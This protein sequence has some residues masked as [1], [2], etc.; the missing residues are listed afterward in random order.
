MPEARAKRR[1]Y[2]RRNRERILEAQKA[3]R[4]R[5]ELGE[6]KARKEMGE[7]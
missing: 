2:Y 5:K 3:Y 4:V 7:K 6:Y 1:A